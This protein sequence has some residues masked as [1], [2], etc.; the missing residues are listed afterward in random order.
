MTHESD[1]VMTTLSAIHREYDP[2]HEKGPTAPVPWYTF[3]LISVASSLQGQVDALTRRLTVIE[4]HLEENH[5]D[6]PDGPDD[7]D[8]PY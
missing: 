5:Y 4:K 3:N 1:N 8:L 6:I 2:H 7:G